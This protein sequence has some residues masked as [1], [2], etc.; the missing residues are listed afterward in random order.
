MCGGKRQGCFGSE[1][2]IVPSHTWQNDVEASVDNIWQISPFG[3]MLLV[4]VFLFDGTNDASVVTVEKVIISWQKVL[5]KLRKGGGN[6]ATPTSSSATIHLRWY[7][8]HV[9]RNTSCPP[10]FQLFE[11]LFGPKRRPKILNFYPT[12]NF[13]H[14]WASL[15]KDVTLLTPPE[16]S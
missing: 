4:V 5:G 9:N 1:E 16:M 12:R 14:F 8:S 11:A 6:G 13:G 2:P 15:L 7:V 3:H 10:F